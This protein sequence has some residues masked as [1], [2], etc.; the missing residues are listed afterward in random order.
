[1]AI[2]TEGFKTL[3]KYC[4]STESQSWF[5]KSIVESILNQRFDLNEF[6]NI[7]YS[8]SIE[9][10]SFQQW[11]ELLF[12]PL[13]DV[14]ELEAD[15]MKLLFTSVKNLYF[16]S[17]VKENSV[18]KED[19]SELRINNYHL[20]RKNSDITSLTADLTKKLTP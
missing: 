2:T 1:M 10:F 8:C 4:T 11:N 18:L 7:L 6:L 13:T 12:I 19:M 16:D 17:L 3:V 9:A 20:E 15:L 5:I 14:E